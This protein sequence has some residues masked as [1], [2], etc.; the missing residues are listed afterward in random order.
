M[1]AEAKIKLSRQADQNAVD[2]A[3]IGKGQKPSI[4]EVEGQARYWTGAACWN[5]WSVNDVVVDTTRWTGYY[6]WNCSA[7]FEV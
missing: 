4:G 1:A 2:P 7:Y 3:R 5:C 6:C